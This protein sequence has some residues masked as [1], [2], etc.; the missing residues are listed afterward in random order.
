MSSQQ[1]QMLRAPSDINNAYDNASLFLN[2]YFH[3]LEDLG[4]LDADVEQARARR[5][6]LQAKVRL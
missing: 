6:E 2:T 1:I 5:D 3:S 4:R